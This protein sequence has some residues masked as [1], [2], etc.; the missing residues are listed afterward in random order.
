MDGCYPTPV[1]AKL[2]GL[3][4]STLHQWNKRGFLRPTTPRSPPNPSLYTFRDVVALRVLADLCARG[5]EIHCLTRVI[6]YLRKRKGLELTTSELLASTLLLTDGH[7]VYE[8]D[9]PIGTSTLR[10]P[11][12]TV[13]LVP[14]GRIVAKLQA[15]ALKVKAA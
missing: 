7:D 3:P 4:P 15:A 1:A 10:D 14:F 5:I 6:A 8:V 12:Q 9:G 11:D 13:M 2:A